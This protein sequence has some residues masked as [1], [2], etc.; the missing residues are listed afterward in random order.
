MLKILPFPLGC[1]APG[2]DQQK[3]TPVTAAGDR[4]LPRGCNLAL[5]TIFTINAPQS[6]GNPAMAQGTAALWSS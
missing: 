4:S 1:A 6:E 2:G 5:C 3:Y